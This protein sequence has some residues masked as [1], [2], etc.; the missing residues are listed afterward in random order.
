MNEHITGW[1]V[2]IISLNNLWVVLDYKKLFSTHKK[3]I[4]K[5]SLENLLLCCSYDCLI[6]WTH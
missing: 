4:I 5:Q 2:K 6:A 3:L 1:R